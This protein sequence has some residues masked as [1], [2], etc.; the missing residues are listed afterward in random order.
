VR[1]GDTTITNATKGQTGTITFQHALNYSLNTGFVTVARRLGDGESITL[2]ARRTMYRYFHDRFHLAVPTGIELSGEAAGVMMLPDDPNGAAVQYSNMTFGQGMNVTMVQ[3][4]AAFSSLINGGVYHPP[5][6]VAGTVE[7]GKVLKAVPKQPTDGVISKETSDTIRDMTLKARRAFYAGN[8]KPGYQIGGKTG[9]SQ[10]AKNHQ[11][12]FGE[13][14]GSYLG[15]GGDDTPRYVI[16]VQLS[17]D[18]MTLEGGRHAL[19]VFTDISNWMI[20][21]LQLQPKG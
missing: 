20:D 12:G 14:I 2:Q 3:V 18:N 7:D 11:Y 1:V 15:F 4:A 17:G 9:T 5:T 8:D 16:M 10:V 13:T 21:Y 6:I 19:P